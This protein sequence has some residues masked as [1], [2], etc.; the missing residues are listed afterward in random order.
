MSLTIE[1]SLDVWPGYDLKN[2]V[3]FAN[4][5]MKI[6]GSKRYRVVFE[7]PNPDEPDGEVR[8]VAE[9]VE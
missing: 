2:A 1:L 6:A 4:P 8:P 5:G 3:A 9:E 7:I